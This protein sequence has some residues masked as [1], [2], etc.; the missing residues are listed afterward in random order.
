MALVDTLTGRLKVDFRSWLVR[1][2]GTTVEGKDILEHTKEI[3]LANG[4]SSNQAVGWFSSSFTAT[5]S[6]ITISLA[7][8]DPLGSSG[9]DA[10]T[11]D[12][13][14]LKIRALF[15][16]NTNSTNYVELALGT[17]G[18]TGWLGGTLPTVKIPAGG[19]YFQ[20]FP[21]GLNEMEEGVSDEIKITSNSAN[22]IVK[23]SY[24]FG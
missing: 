16:E 15:V 12:P 11:Q 19:V 17:N 9:D 5:T 22:C 24:L 4:N 7:S 2:Q 13:E 14:G 3:N 20:N 1:T 18:I 6:G 10:P 8:L 21:N 23:I